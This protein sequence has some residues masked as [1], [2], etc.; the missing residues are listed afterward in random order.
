[1]VETLIIGGV[2]IFVLAGGLGIFL[3]LRVQRLFIE[4]VRKQ[5]AA[6][7]RAEEARRQVWEQ[8]QQREM[9]A[10]KQSLANQVEQLRKAYEER[11]NQAISQFGVELELARL[12]RVDETPILSKAAEEGAAMP[13]HWRPA[14]LYKADLSQRDLSH[15]YLGRADLRGA[16][17]VGANLS[18][19][20]LSRACL[21][22]ADLTRANLTGANLSYADLREANLSEATLLVADLHQTNLTGA[23]LDNVYSLTEE[24]LRSA[25]RGSQPHSELEVEETSPRMPAVRPTR[26]IPERPAPSTGSSASRPRSH[27]GPAAAETALPANTT[28][29]SSPRS[30]PVGASSRVEEAASSFASAVIPPTTGLPANQESPS[31]STSS[32][33]FTASTAPESA[34]AAASLSGNEE[35]EEPSTPAVVPDVEADET[36]QQM[37]GSE[38]YFSPESLAYMM[39][40]RPAGQQPEIPAWLK[41]L[42]TSSGGASLNFTSSAEAEPQGFPP[43]STA[44]EEHGVTAAE[45]TE[46]SFYA[47]ESLEQQEEFPASATLPWTASTWERAWKEAVERFSS[48]SQEERGAAEGENNQEA[49]GPT[50]NAS[51]FTFRVP[52]TA[53]E[54]QSTGGSEAQ[55]ESSA[56]A[57]STDFPQVPETPFSV[58]TLDTLPFIERLVDPLPQSERT[59]TESLLDPQ[60]TDHIVDTQELR[61][62][63]QKSPAPGEQ[64]SS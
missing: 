50:A 35:Q 58:P 57:S 12:P 41:A 64:A 21:A 62:I 10:Q 13:A 37:E 48:F 49:E 8:K 29:T 60:V 4:S 22:G 14:N 16:R 6:W 23:R 51:P 19:A 46:A 5:Q 27:D 40:E 42:E 11:L 54:T 47:S 45:S 55:E 3:G 1:M 25:I 28:S 52:D 34:S 32:P 2:I 18:M 33:L 24:Q 31:S 43:P 36:G 9:A 44:D 7:E 53:Y 63:K 59:S 38:D 61:A 39:E 56:S 26:I 17:L 30:G 15:R 20:D